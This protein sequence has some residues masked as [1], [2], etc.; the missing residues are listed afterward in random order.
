[1]YG[2]GVEFWKSSNGCK[3]AEMLSLV[4]TSPQVEVGKIFS[5][6]WVQY[7]TLLFSFPAALENVDWSLVSDDVPPFPVLHDMS[8]KFGTLCPPLPRCQFEDAQELRQE[9]LRFATFF[10]VIR[11]SAIQEEEDILNALF[12]DE[13]SPVLPA[14]K[15]SNE[16]SAPSAVPLG[17]LPKVQNAVENSIKDHNLHAM[18]IAGLDMMV[19]LPRCSASHPHHLATHSVLDAGRPS[20]LC[21]LEGR[22]LRDQHQHL[23]C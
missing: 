17:L 3:E 22:Q 18:V 16:E 2:I 20:T 19:V 9:T 10:S 4:F 14:L 11:G 1:V 7:L 13:D 6:A 23:G 8:L 21:L 5:A 12:A 15:P